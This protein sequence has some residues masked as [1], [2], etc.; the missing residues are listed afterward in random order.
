[1]A[2]ARWALA[3]VLVVEQTRSFRPARTFAFE[4]YCFETTATIENLSC[5]RSAQS[6]PIVPSP[7]EYAAKGLQSK[8]S[9]QTIE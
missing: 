8:Y 6:E 3:I 2:D 4:Y 1:M 7:T 5:N 9:Q